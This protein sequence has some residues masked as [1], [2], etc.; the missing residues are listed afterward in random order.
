MK[1][2][3]VTLSVLVGLSLY[4]VPHLAA[5]QMM[6][7]AN[8]PSRSTTLHLDAQNDDIRL[9]RTRSLKKALSDIERKYGV[10]FAYDEQLINGRLVDA[11]LTG[12]TLEQTLINTLAGQGLRFRKIKDNLFVI[13]A[14]PA[15]KPVTATPLANPA[16]DRSGRGTAD[17]VGAPVSEAVVKRI[18]GRI[19]DENNAG[20]PGANVIEK[21][22]TNGATTDADGNFVINASDNATTLT[23][24]SV[25]YTTQDITIGDQA[26]INVKLVP[27]D[28]TLNEVVVIGYQTVRKKDL[29][30]AT[31]VISPTQSNRV[32]AN[33]LAESIQGLSPGVTVRNTGL[34]GQGSSIQIRGVASF[35]NTDPLY[36]IDG[37]I[38]D[39][40][41]TINT[42]DIESIQVLKDAS[43]AA[44]YGSRA[45]NGVII[46]TT[47]QGKEGPVK[48]SFSAKYGAQSLY[49]R[50]DVTDAQGFAALQRDQYRNS[51]QPIPGSINVPDNQLIN[52]NW[53]DQVLQ[54][55][56]LQDYNLTLSGG[57]ASSSYL[58]SGSYFNNK[59]YVQGTGFDRVSARIN[60]RSQ[61]GRVTVG[62]NMVLTNSN[63]QNPPGY[64]NPIYDMA[65][66]LPVIPVQDP[67]YV[68]AT[69]P[70]GYGIGTIPDAISYAYNPV[71]ARNLVTNKSNFAKIVGNAFVDVK[72]LD[73]LTYRFNAGLE[74]SFDYTQNL[75]KIGV[76]QYSAAPVPSSI[77]E[78]R[79]RFTSTLFEHTLNFNRTFGAHSI[80]GVL[81]VSQQNTQRDITSGS[82]TNLAQSGGQYF[83]TINAATGVSNSGGATPDKYSILGYIGRVNYAYNDRYL[84]TLTGR[85]D[86]DSRFGANYRVGFFPS[87]AAAWR[88]SQEE[89]F[90]VGWISDLKL[91]AS[92]GKLGIVVPTLGSFPY[93][94]FIN[95]NPRAI[96][97]VDQTPNVGAYQAQLA[98]PDLRWEERT[99]Q[100]IGLTASFLNNRI[101]TEINVYN[102]LSTD[103]ILNLRVPGYL[104]NLRGDPFVN[105]ASI[106]N[107]G[108]ELALTY[109]DNSKAVKWDVSGNFTTIKNRIENVGNQGLNINYIQSGNTRSQVGQ[110]VGQ[111]FVLKTAGIF[112]NQGE[113]DAYVNRDGTRIQPNAKPGDIRYVDTDGNGTINVDDRQYVGSP[114]PTLQAGLQG[115]ASY[116]GFSLNVQLVGVFGYTVYNSVRAGLDGYQNTNFR[117]DVSPWS[118]TNTNT[119]D[120]RIGLQ[121]DDLGIQSN[122]LAYTDRW[123][124]NASYGRI[125]N[126]ELG[127]TLPAPLLSRAKVRNA[128][129]YVSGQNLFT[130]TKYTGLDPDVTGANIQ[131]RGVDNGHYPS[132]RVISVGITG[133]F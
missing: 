95:S 121:N 8:T 120:P 41:P 122:N 19:T 42:N 133:D 86:Q 110:S 36:I 33:S 129:V 58:V 46:I 17:V 118:P 50:W 75:R 127:Y 106:R 131:E 88:I 66:M 73:G 91:S 113:I 4:S 24:S 71:A 29:T 15:P 49:R 7:R 61:I 31:D 85:V 22:T 89:F 35:L 51:G 21:G 100:N 101:S 130:V 69:N 20:L 6:T 40:N 79:S 44:I 10:N 30:G 54:T 117:R 11:E 74:A 97:G 81:G 103:A 56:N 99:Q 25:G 83:E 64:I 111:W 5:A 34:P 68:N 128:R 96:F 102:S 37:M 104:G 93:T 32:T 124:E 13:Q 18:T 1:N 92:Y 65:Y 12:N 112:Q 63:I 107:R 57:N 3:Y 119:S 94:A 60:T 105:T 115:N 39:A 82:R 45:A 116:K 125:R 23:V 47:K 108:V 26:V 59:G 90:N 55:G 62:E 132:P 48:V 27:D 114:W 123:L 16:T 38:A 76:Y 67:R 2:R 80:N 28:R 78:D 126:I 52:T 87:V 77:G 109:R 53:Q 9:N 43:A 98:N 72:I 70:E 84:L 14:A